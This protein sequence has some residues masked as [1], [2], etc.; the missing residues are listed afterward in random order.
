MPS[1][2]E[3]R[4]LDAHRTETREWERQYRLKHPDRIKEN[5]KRHR[6]LQTDIHS[7]ATLEQ[8]R[9]WHYIEKHPE[10]VGKEC[11]FCGEL[12]EL[13]GHHPDY[14]YPEIVVTCCHSCHMYIEKGI[15]DEN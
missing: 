12:E 9:A 1:P 14:S 13:K 5:S 7:S 15:G 6:A 2:C 11:E 10:L 8:Q 4:W 3:R